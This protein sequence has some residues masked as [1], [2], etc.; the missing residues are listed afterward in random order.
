VHTLRRPYRCADCGWRGWL[1]PLEQ[2]T[3]FFDGYAP[4]ADAVGPSGS[5]GRQ[6]PAP[7]PA[8]W[9]PPPGAEPSE[10]RHAGLAT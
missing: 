8:A 2:A 4:A 6:S 5:S 3:P 9:A 1:L 10:S 7:S